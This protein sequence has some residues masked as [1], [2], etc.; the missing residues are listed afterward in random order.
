MTVL[1]DFY[2]FRLKA[3]SI[4]PSALVDD[5]KRLMIRE[6]MSDVTFLV[7]GKEVFANRAI[8]AVRSDYFDVMLYGGMRESRR[9]EEGEAKPIEVQDVSHAVFVKV[10]EYLY[11]DGVSEL[12][13]DLSVPLLIASE[14]YMLDRLKALCED[15]IRKEITVD[16]V[17]GVLIASHQHNA[18]G[19]K[20]IAL[21]FILNNLHDPTVVTGLSVRST[22]TFLLLVI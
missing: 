6:E 3:V 21:E 9:D 12:T 8:L 17:I 22:F 15:F 7:E 13:W 14:Q 1:N 18:V 2:K 20:D 4:P 19:L 10:I 5:M 11:T 16:N